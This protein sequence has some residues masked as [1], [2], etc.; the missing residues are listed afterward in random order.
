MSPRTLLRSIRVRYSEEL[1]PRTAM[2]EIGD[3]RIGDHFGVRLP[4]E[5]V[6]LI[7]GQMVS[8]G[9]WTASANNDIRLPNEIAPHNCMAL[10]C[11]VS[12]DPIY[13]VTIIWCPT[14]NVL[15]QTPFMYC[16]PSSNLHG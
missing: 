7:F 13:T 2:F 15:S 8:Q 6:H 10:I 9:G 1:G 16:V 12:P 4:M 5:S 11:D 14:F 3:C